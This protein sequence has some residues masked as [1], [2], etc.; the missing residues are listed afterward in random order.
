MTC[1]SMES[2]TATGGRI[3]I[4]G[5]FSFQLLS[6]FP[7]SLSQPFESFTFNFVPQAATLY[8]SFYLMSTNGSQKERESTK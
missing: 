7:L 8:I 3:G 1:K 4:G 6:F 2:F 5:W